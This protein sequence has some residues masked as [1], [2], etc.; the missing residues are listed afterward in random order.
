M[1][2]WLL[3]CCWPSA[4]GSSLSSLYPVVF[5]CLHLFSRSLSS[6]AELSFLSAIKT[7]SSTMEWSCPHFH[8]LLPA[9]NCLLVLAWLLS[10]VR[11]H[12]PKSN[13]WEER[14]HFTHT[15]SHSPSWRDTGTGSS[16]QELKQRPPEERCLLMSLPALTQG[17]FVQSPA[18][19]ARDGW[20]RLH[21]LATLT[22]GRL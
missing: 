18:L 1:L 8:S 14:V 20:T 3:L 21:Q 9:Q 17:P 16:R 13:S 10:L 12:S 2:S 5:L 11:K 6:L 22:G 15:S 4:L 7:F 19:L